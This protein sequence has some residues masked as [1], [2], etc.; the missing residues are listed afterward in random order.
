[1]ENK[2]KE[3]KYTYEIALWMSRNPTRDISEMD[4]DLKA[5]YAHYK[6]VRYFYKASSEIFFFKGLMIERTCFS[7]EQRL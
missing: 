1:M 3:A 2:V 6:K 5:E 4:L 7:A